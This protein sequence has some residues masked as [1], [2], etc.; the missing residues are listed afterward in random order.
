MVDGITEAINESKAEKIY[1]TNLMTRYNQTHGFKATNFA[2]EIEKYLGGKLDYVIVNNAPL[3]DEINNKYADEK[4]FMVEDDT[5]GEENYK[6]IRDKVWME[7]KEYKRVSSDV[8][9]RSFIRHDPEKI[10]ELIVKI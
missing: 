2:S 7:G 9:P 6:V 1:V 5:T 4:W 3:S 8:V 10:A